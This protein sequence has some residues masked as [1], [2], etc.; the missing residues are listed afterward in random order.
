MVSY[1]KAS[2]NSYILSYGAFESKMIRQC[3]KIKHKIT[4]WEYD[5]KDQD[6]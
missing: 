1:K 4:N 3:K 5:I 2:Y 6:L